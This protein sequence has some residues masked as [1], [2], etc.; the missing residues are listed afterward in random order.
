VCSATEWDAALDGREISQDCD[1]TIRRSFRSQ[2]APERDGLSSLDPPTLH[3]FI[4]EPVARQVLW[5]IESAPTAGEMQ[6]MRTHAM[7]VGQRRND[8]CWKVSGE[9]FAQKRKVLETP[10][11]IKVC[12]AVLS[13]VGLQARGVLARLCGRDGMSSSLGRGRGTRQKHPLSPRAA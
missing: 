3:E 8:T 5:V 9:V 11:G 7:L 13:Q 1:T 6:D 4:G 2:S 10:A 12:R